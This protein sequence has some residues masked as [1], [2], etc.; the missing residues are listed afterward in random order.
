MPSLNSSPLPSQTM[1]QPTPTPSVDTIF[2]ETDET[3][4]FHI[5]FDENNRAT[6]VR[7]DEDER[8]SQNFTPKQGFKRDVRS[9]K[10]RH[11]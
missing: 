6:V 11:I 5:H 2:V 7:D 9:S 8:I 1:I 10:R 3:N 4:P